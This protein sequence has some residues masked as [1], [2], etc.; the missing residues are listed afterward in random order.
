MDERDDGSLDG[1]RVAKPFHR[2]SL[3][4]IPVSFTKKKKK[5]SSCTRNK[6]ETTAKKTQI[7]YYKSLILLDTNIIKVHNT[8]HCIKN[9]LLNIIYAIGMQ[10]LWNIKCIFWYNKSYS[11]VPLP[12]K[13]NISRL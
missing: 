11:M 5:I 8:D 9:T 1:A 13:L 2:R 10:A 6:N 12:H 3:Q 4:E 7:F